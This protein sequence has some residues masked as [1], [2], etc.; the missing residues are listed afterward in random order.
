MLKLNSVL[1][2]YVFIGT[3]L[4]ENFSMPGMILGM[5]FGV[6]FGLPTWVT[7]IRSEHK[8]NLKKI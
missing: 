1:N 5:K 4:G 6:I 3:I 8:I 7:S 2:R